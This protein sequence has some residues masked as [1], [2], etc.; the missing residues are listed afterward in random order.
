MTLQLNFLIYED[1]FIFFFQCTVT[2]KLSLLYFIWPFSCCRHVPSLTAPMGVIHQKLQ[3]EDGFLYFTYASQE[4]FGWRGHTASF[5]Y[6]QLSYWQLKMLSPR[7]VISASPYDCTMYIRALELISL[8]KWH[9][10]LPTST[11]DAVVC[12][13]HTVRHVLRM[14]WSYNAVIT[15]ASWKFAVYMCEH[16]TPDYAV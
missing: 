3:S 12:T 10:Y 6:C 15:T 14:L 16:T 13:V 4:C 1:N 5:Q 7:S 2:K 8:M 11:S 9:L